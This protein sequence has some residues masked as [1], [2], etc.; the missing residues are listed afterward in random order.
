MNQDMRDGGTGGDMGVR[1]EWGRRGIAVGRE[2]WVEEFGGMFG[3]GDLVGTGVKSME[4]ST[5]GRY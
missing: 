3:I 5:E 2:E 1:L 4:R